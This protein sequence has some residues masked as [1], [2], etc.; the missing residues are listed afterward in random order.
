MTIF[1]LASV[2]VGVIAW[3][4]MER[5]FNGGDDFAVNNITG[6][7]KKVTFHALNSKTEDSDGRAISFS[8]NKSYV[9]SITYDWDSNTGTYVPNGEGNTKISL[10]DYDPLDQEHPIMLLF[11]YNDEYDAST[12]DPFAIKVSSTQTDFL[13]GRDPSTNLPIHPLSNTYKGTVDNN[14]YY[15]LSSVVNFY[16]VQLSDDDFD[17]L[18]GGTYYTL[19]K[20]STS[21]SSGNIYLNDSDNFVYVNN[22][23]NVSTFEPE[24]TISSYN[25]GNIRYTAIVIDYYLDAVE[26]IYSTFLGDNTLEVTYDY[27]LKYACDWSMEVI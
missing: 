2:F 12:G 9:G 15:A 18:D 26:Y 3:F 14:P 8:F 7:L 11:E 10:P 21:Q 17:T 6:R 25:T 20:P 24:V 19:Y 27:Y 16:N 13:G 1:S 23:T 5:V 4:Q 22:D